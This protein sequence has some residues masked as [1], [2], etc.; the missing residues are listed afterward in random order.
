MEG[1]LGEQRME[2]MQVE[3]ALKMAAPIDRYLADIEKVRGE[4]KHRPIVN[5]VPTQESKSKVNVLL[6]NLL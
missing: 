2:A 5:K 6:L 4:F 1:L 3:N